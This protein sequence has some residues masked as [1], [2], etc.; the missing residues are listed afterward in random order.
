MHFDK[1]EETK[2]VYFIPQSLITSDAGIP[3]YNFA[4]IERNELYCKFYIFEYNNQ[5]E[6]NEKLYTI[7]VKWDGEVQINNDTHMH[8]IWDDYHFKY[9]IDL[10]TSIRNICNH[11]IEYMKLSKKD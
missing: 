5:D 2:P 3:M 11:Y 9:Y 7:V 1:N 10:F 8:Q 4:E 6:T